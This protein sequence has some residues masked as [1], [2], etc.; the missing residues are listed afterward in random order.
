M[1][2]YVP[3][4]LEDDLRSSLAA[5]PVTAILGPRQCGKTTLA[6]HVLQDRSDAVTLDLEKPSDLNKI[7]DPELFFHLHRDKLVCVDEVQVRPDLFP[8]LRVV[9]D[10]DRRPGKVL[11]LGSASQELVRKSSESLAGRIHYIDLSPFGYDELLADNPSRYKEPITPWVRGGFPDAVL[12]PNDAVSRQWREDFVRTFL[13]RDIPQL[14]I[15]IPAVTTRRFWTMLAHCHGQI[16]NLS[17]LGQA[18]GVTHPTISRYLDIMVQTFMVRLLPPMVANT[19]KRL[20]KSPKVYL[21]DSGILHTLLA[22]NG[23]E[24][25][26]GHPVVGASWEGWCLEQIAPLL[27]GWQASFYR[28]ASGEEVDLVLERG[29]QRLAFEFKSTMAPKLSKGFD[30]TMAVIKPDRTWVVAPVTEA[31]PLKPGVTVTNPRLLVRELRA[32]TAQD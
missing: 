17:K 13:E 1:Q 23:A 2:R 16:V 9:V 24:D 21:R 26:L 28:T 15:T 19:K 3:R 27:P 25:L 18:L 32:P 31:Y 29:R 6:R 12:A 30:G 5:F 20:V 8:L 7:D 22:L 4:R 10:E 11:L 14:G